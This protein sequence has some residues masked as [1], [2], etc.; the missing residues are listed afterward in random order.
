MLAIGRFYNIKYFVTDLVEKLVTVK[1][2]PEKKIC[3]FSVIKLVKIEMFLIF[4]FNCVKC[5]MRKEKF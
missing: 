4:F 3:T 5:A 2:T 1:I